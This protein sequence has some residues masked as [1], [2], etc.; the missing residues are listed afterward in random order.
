MVAGHLVVIFAWHSHVLTTTGF[1]III[2]V[3]NDCQKYYDATVDFR[4]EPPLSVSI[5]SVRSQ[6][7][8]S[9]NYGYPYLL[10]L[11]WTLTPYSILAIRLLKTTLYFVSL[12]CLARVWRR[13]YGN[14]LAMWGFAFFGFIFTPALYYNFRN[15]KD[16]LIL[17]LFI[18]SA[19]GPDQGVLPPDPDGDDSGED[20]E[21]SGPQKTE[22]A[23][24]GSASVH[25]H[26]EMNL[27]DLE[28][29][30]APVIPLVIASGAGANSRVSLGT[31][32][33]GGMLM[34]TVAGVFLIPLLYVLV[35]LAAEKLG[36]GKSTPPPVIPEPEPPPTGP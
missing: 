15:L 20:I 9:R 23:E 4:N 36:G 22:S 8:E 1:P 18:L 29:K 14:R 30:I 13:D 6:L 32:V 11:L 21:I 12:S 24:E 25:Y 19:C 34:A 31:A 10:A 3:H 17:A 35:Q 27:P 26:Y 33:F 7:D 5:A 28:Y 2:D 16:G